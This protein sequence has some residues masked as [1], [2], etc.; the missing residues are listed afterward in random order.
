MNVTGITSTN[1]FQYRC[2]ITNCNG[3]NNATSNVATLTVNPLPTVITVGT[4]TQ[5]TCGVA[6]GTVAVSALPA[7]GN[8]TINPGNHT[9][10]GT[11]TT[12]TGL[13]SGTYNF[14]VTNSASCTS[15]PASNVVINVQPVTPAAPAVGTITQPTCNVTTGTV[16]LNGLPATGSWTLNPGNIVGTGTSKTLSGLATGTTTYTVKNADLCTSVSSANVV[17]NAAPAPQAA[18]TIGTIT[19]PSCSV[20]TGTV[21]LN[22]LPATGNWTVNPG[23]ISGIGSSLT[24]PG[25]TVGTHTYTVTNNIAC[26][27]VASANVVINAQPATP[28]APV[29]G[30]LTHPTC[31]SATGSAVLS[32]LPA[33]GTWTLT[34]VADNTTTTG[35][36]VSTT[37]SGILSGTHNYKVT[38]SVGCTSVVSS[39]VVI[40]TQPETPTAPMVGTITSPTCSVLTGSV[41]L[42]NLPTTGSWTLN[43]GN[44]NGSGSTYTVSGLASGNLT[45][46]VTNAAGCI[47]AASANVAIPTHAVAPATPSITINVNVLHSSSATGNQWYN[48]NGIIIG[49]TGQDLTVMY[50]TGY[51]VIV[52]DGVCAS[53]PSNTINVTN[54]GIQNVDNNN[55][56]SVYPNPFTNELAIEADGNQNIK[57]FEIFNAVGQVVYTGHE[58]TKAVVS[59]TN[60]A[61]GMYLLRIQTNNATQYKKIIKE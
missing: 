12:L 58:T 3:N 18:P 2:Y 56:I 50:N 27:S 55:K 16:V 26:T 46:K 10:S 31:A 13:S 7:S 33:T 22:N 30:T 60:F 21:V 25:V 11:T 40:N 39:D 24:I 52:N 28:S 29:V 36:G 9:G 14:T 37:V 51:Y 15:V 4:I 57:S 43:P 48:S 19:Q 20:A 53:S 34:R 17:I 8:W 44:I 1:T 6:T 35:S 59:T 38:N 41:L 42:Y 47:S 32:G 23:N 54:V 45:F 5:P 61:P 49:A